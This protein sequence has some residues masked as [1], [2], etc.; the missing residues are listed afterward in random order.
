MKLFSYLACALMGISFLANPTTLHANRCK[1][2]KQGPEGPPGPA[3]PQGPQ[4]IQGI[5]GNQGIQGIQGTVGPEGPPGPAGT[6]AGLAAYSFFYSDSD[7][8][9]DREIA[10][11]N[12][13]GTLY[14]GIV[15]FE[16]TNIA[17]HPNINVGAFTTQTGDTVRPTNIIAIGV[18][19]AGYYKVTTYISTNNTG[20]SFAVVKNI[21]DIKPS[22]SGTTHNAVAGTFGLIDPGFAGIESKIAFNQTIV[23]LNAGDRLSIINDDPNNDLALSAHDTVF[24]PP[25]TKGVSA[26]MTIEFLGTGP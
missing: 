11:P 4:G 7:Q 12:P 14:Y 18:P 21:G 15:E 20:G 25:Y 17:T 2:P 8:Q 6:V 24:L 1:A 5:Q 23:S 22:P 16:A 3:G 26:S 10:V 13:G 9:V 19:T